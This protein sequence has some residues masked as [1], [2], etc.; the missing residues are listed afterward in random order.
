M[1]VAGIRDRS[2]LESA[3]AVLSEGGLVIHPTETVYGIGCMVDGPGVQ[4]LREAKRRGSSGFVLLIPGFEQARE[5][6][7]AAGSR[8]AQAFWPGPLTLV[9]H[10]DRSRFPPEVKADDGSVAV[11]VCGNPVT[12]ELVA[13]LG[14][15]MTST[16]ANRPGGSPAVT[17]AE[18]L[19][20]CDA[21]G[22]TTF[23]LDGGTLPGQPP[24]T[25]VDVR[26]DSWTVIRRGAVPQAELRRIAGPP[27]GPGGGETTRRHR[28]DDPR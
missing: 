28:R 14:A 15:P 21:M 26:G 8:L 3:A 10:D 22:L 16:S 2:V 6:L 27:H 19:D 17:L 18:A 5:L 11:R 25:I 1:S 9:C 20:A 23:G 13:R 4:K 7:G 24:S 12:R